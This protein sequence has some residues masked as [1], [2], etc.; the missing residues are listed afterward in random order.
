MSR[1]KKSTVA[2]VLRNFMFD[3]PFMGFSTKFRS[4]PLRGGKARTHILNY[5]GSCREELIWDTREYL[6]QKS[7]A[8]QKIRG[9]WRIR[10]VKTHRLD[11]DHRSLKQPNITHLWLNEDEDFSGDFSKLVCYRACCVDKF[12][13]MMDALVGSL[14]VVL[15]PDRYEGNWWVT[16]PEEAT[17]KI[18]YG[19][20][21][22]RWFG[23]DNFFLH[24]PVLTSLVMGLFRQGSLLFQQGFDEAIL[25]TVKRKEVEEALTNSDPVLA[26]QIL[27]K[28]R[29]WIEV[30][31]KGYLN[32]APFP[33]GYWNRLGLL[34]RALYKYGYD[35]VFAGDL[36]NSWNIHDSEEGGDED[37]IENNPRYEVS[38]GPMKYWGTYRNLART[39][40]VDGKRLAQL[41]K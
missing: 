32:L 6:Q 5:G 21:E 15:N 19:P 2:G 18:T 29:P 11:V 9:T 22:Y 12:L 25:K 31:Q 16:G 13:E 1:Q 4:Q 33:R 35:E 23:I 7:V 20:P 24:H 30:P 37:L 14:G 34:H 41:G 40:S 39:V 38:T 27:T 10:Q 26:M 28:L 3:Q 17:K 8:T 36:Q